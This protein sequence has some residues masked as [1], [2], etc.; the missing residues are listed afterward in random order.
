MKTMLSILLLL[1][2]I[3][4]SN[5]EVCEELNDYALIPGIGVGPYKIGMSEEKLKNILCKSYNKKEI[6]A[7]FSGDVTTYY[8]I[9]NMTFKLENHRLK[10]IIVWGSFS[11]MYEDL[12]VDYTLEEIEYYGEVIEHKGEYRILEKPGISFAFEDSEEGKGISIF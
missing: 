12:D 4:C 2:L 7:W 6:E 8:F 1:F 5:K 11:G 10:K 9:K 3:S